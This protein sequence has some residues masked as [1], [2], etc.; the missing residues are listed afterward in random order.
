MP[1]KPTGKMT[2]VQRQKLFKLAAKVEELY[3]NIGNLQDGDT[4]ALICAAAN[5]LVSAKRRVKGEE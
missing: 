2:S 3:M 4:V 5:S 1:R